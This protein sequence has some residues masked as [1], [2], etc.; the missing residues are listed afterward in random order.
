M[1]C[2]NDRVSLYQ[3]QPYKKDPCQGMASAHADKRGRF[4][5]ARSAAFDPPRDWG[6]LPVV[7]VSA[8]LKR[9]RKTRIR[10]RKTLCEKISMLRTLQPQRLK[11]VDFSRGAIWLKPYPDTNLSR[12]RTLPPRLQKRS[13]EQAMP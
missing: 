10:E 8:R 12:M 2:Q 4:D 7:L 6:L 9:R 11:P 3:H 5:H 1:D 13:F